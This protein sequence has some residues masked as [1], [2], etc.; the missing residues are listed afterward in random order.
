MLKAWF[1]FSLQDKAFPSDDFDDPG[2]VTMSYETLKE[3]IVSCGFARSGRDVDAVMET[4]NSMAHI[5]AA[6]A[7]FS[8]C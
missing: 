7:N 2:L 3:Q 5:Y 8:G 4:L 1:K 6:H